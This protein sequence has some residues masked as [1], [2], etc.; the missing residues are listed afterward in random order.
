MNIRNRKIDMTSVKSR[1]SGFD[2]QQM[3]VYIGFVA[4]FI[5]FAVTLYDDGFLTQRNLTNIL[6]QTAPATI[7]AVGLVFA[8]SAG[9]IDLSFGSIVAVSAL[10]SAVVL[11]EYSLVFGVAA[12]LQ[13]GSRLAH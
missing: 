13:S 12:G 9:E 5:F 4:I 10:T 2:F 8:L 7:M 3:V 11:Q 6:L 1:L